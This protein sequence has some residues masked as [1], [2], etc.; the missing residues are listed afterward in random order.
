MYRRAISIIAAG[1]GATALSA[2]APPVT[3]PAVAARQQAAHML[4]QIR[5]SNPQEQPAMCSIPLLEARVTKN[6]ERMPTLRPP[7]GPDS[8]DHMPRVKLP[9]PP[10]QEEK[11]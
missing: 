1:I 9:A 11:R 6:L 5:N 10:C 8:I 4:R 7:A 3:P 2:Q